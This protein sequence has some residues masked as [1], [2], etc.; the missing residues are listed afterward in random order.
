MNLEQ[1]NELLNL[2]LPL[3]DEYQTLGGFILYQFQKIPAQGETL[4]FDN[5]ELTVVSAEGPRLHQIRI[6]RRDSASIVQIQDEFDISA[7]EAKMLRAK[8][9]TL[10][11]DKT[12]L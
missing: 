3:I 8:R 10:P 7:T 11:E 6:H 5:L 1:V 9:A 4:H 2:N 12:P